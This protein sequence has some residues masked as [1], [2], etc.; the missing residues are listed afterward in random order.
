MVLDIDVFQPGNNSPSW[1]QRRKNRELGNW[2][3]L[4]DGAGKSDYRSLSRRRLWKEWD[5]DWLLFFCL[6]SIFGLWKCCQSC[7]LPFPMV[8]MMRGSSRVWAGQSDCSVSLGLVNCVGVHMNQRG[9]GI[10]IDWYR[11]WQ[12]EFSFFLLGLEAKRWYK[13]GANWD[14]FPAIWSLFEAE[15]IVMV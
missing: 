8:W 14:M 3:E 2:F 9:H 10:F 15:V 4:V 12:E 6:L 11:C 13:P 5:E 7:S 1:I